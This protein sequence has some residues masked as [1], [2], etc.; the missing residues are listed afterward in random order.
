MIN[1]TNLWI[2]VSHIHVRDTMIILE[3]YHQTHLLY[4]K[5]DMF[6]PWK[7]LTGRHTSIEMYV[8]AGSGEETEMS[9]SGRY[10][11]KG[12][13]GIVTGIFTPFLHDIILPL[14]G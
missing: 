2:H 1:N 8:R 6:S 12:R 10:M 4:T 9:G 11:I 5:F 13:V 14:P 7:E 3:E